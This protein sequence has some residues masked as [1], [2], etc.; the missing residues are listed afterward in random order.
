MGLP[1]YFN[2]RFSEN[3]NLNQRF[4]S[5]TSLNYL[6]NTLAVG[7]YGSGV[8]IY[9]SGGI[10]EDSSGWFLNQKLTGQTNIGSVGEGFGYAVKL[11]GIGNIL[12]ISNP[13][14][15]NTGNNAIGAIYVYSKNNNNLWSLSKKI[16]GSSGSFQTFGKS[17][18]INYNGNIISVGSPYLTKT[19]SVYIF[20]SGIL[21]WQLV[22][23]ITGN[24][25]S[26][27]ESV[28]LNKSGDIIA[29][30][31]PYENQLSGKVYTLNWQLPNQI[32][33]KN[34][35]LDESSVDISGIYT[36]QNNIASVRGIQ[37]KNK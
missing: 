25:Y 17:L 31:S 33:L 10:Y 9:Q 7:T 2:Q 29:I 13:S 11:N 12:A 30:G 4:G 3:N 26:F 24:N 16:T 37:M 22:R 19:G 36:Y 1:I 28:S 34:W 23:T 32:K 14:E 27:G 21:D 15:I 8:Y 35:E 6:G 20:E 5:N 18:D